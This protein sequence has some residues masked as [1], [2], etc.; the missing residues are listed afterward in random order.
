[1]GLRRI[2]HRV[3]DALLTLLPGSRDDPASIE[4]RF[5]RND[6]FFEKSLDDAFAKAQRIID[7]AVAE[8]NR[9]EAAATEQAERAL[10]SARA[11]AE[12][13]TAR[14]KALDVLING[15]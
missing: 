10:A 13:A 12:A 2:I 8:T 5:R 11:I 9:I 4:A 3:Y 7:A 15:E 14:A 1:M 6:D